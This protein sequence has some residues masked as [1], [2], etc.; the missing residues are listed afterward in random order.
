MQ[1]ALKEWLRG[2]H[3]DVLSKSPVHP[4]IIEAIYSLFEEWK[5]NKEVYTYNF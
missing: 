4:D 2:P 3:N 5:G 1:S